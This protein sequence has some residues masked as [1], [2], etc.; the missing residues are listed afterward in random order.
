M[1]KKQNKINEIY[2]RNIKIN[3]NFINV[4]NIGISLLLYFIDC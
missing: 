1:F 2:I 4:V 3:C